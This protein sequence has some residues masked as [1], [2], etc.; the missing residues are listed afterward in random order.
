[1][2]TC[3]LKVFDKNNILCIILRRYKIK[4][5]YYPINHYERGGRYYFISTGVIEGKDDAIK[6]YVRDIRKL[7]DAKKG[8][9]VDYFEI[10]GN[11]FT[12]VSSHSID[13]ENKLMV[14]VAFN[15]ALIHY[16][17]VIWHPDGWEEFCVAAMNR[18]DIE[19]LIKIATKVYKLKLLEFKQK[20]IT[21]LGFVTI[22][23][24]ITLKQKKAIELAMENGYY[25]YPRKIELEKLAKMSKIALSTYAVH[26]RKAEKKLLPYV[27]KQYK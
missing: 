7:H 13:E 2:W 23:P 17:P 11:Y 9:R 4:F 22:L 18:A 14:K 6:K 26:L 5:L 1:M 10:E 27:A 15:P 20:K 3:R 19:E 25:E 12:I 21:N 8:R 24:E 16:R